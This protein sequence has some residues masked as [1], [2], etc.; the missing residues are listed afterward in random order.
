MQTNTKKFNARD[1]NL[2]LENLITY[3]NRKKVAEIK[4]FI[5]VCMFVFFLSVEIAPAE[6]PTPT[7]PATT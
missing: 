5:T 4:M 1:E 6:R 2:K 7:V 3:K